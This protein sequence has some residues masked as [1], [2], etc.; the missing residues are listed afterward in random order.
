MVYTG[1]LYLTFPNDE[2]NSSL[3]IQSETVAGRDNSMTHY[4]VIQDFNSTS[5]DSVTL[6]APSVRTC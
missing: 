4:R 1:V 2:H 6:Q 5:G 3:T